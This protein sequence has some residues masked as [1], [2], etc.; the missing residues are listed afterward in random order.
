MGRVTSP[1]QLENFR[2][3]D[4][5]IL[6]FLYRLL[7]PYSQP[8]EKEAARNGKFKW[9]CDLDLSLECEKIDK[10]DSKYNANERH[11]ILL[12]HEYVMK[13]CVGQKEEDDE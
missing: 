1:N 2:Q 12:A 3:E 6:G 13:F 8:I 10:K 5:E 4:G 9:M 11:Q 7:S